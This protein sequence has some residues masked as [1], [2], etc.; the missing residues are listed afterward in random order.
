VRVPQPDDPRFRDVHRVWKSSGLSAQ[1]IANY[2]WWARVFVAD[3]RMRGRDPDSCLTRRGVV[4]FIEQREAPRGGTVA[5]AMRAGPSALWAWSWG[6]AAC[7]HVVPQWQPPPEP[8]KP[9]RR[10]LGQFVDYRREVCGVAAST[11][12]LDVANLNRFVAFLDERGRRPAR[13]RLVDVD[14]YLVHGS[15]RWAPRTLQGVAS[16]IRAFL[17]FLHVSGRLRHDLATSVLA[18]RERRDAHPPRALPWSDVRHILAAV[19]RSTRYGLRDHAL[20]LTMATYG[21]GAGEAFALTLDDID[22]RGGT[23][24]VVRPKTGREIVLPLLGPVARS[25]SA[26]LRRARPPHASSRVVFVQL[27]APFE[28]YRAAGAAWHVLRK[29][30]RAAG[31]SA[32]YL[33]SHVLR[34]SH[35][36]RHVDLGHPLKIVADILGHVDTETTSSY[37]RVSIRRLRSLALPVPS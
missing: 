31:V 7:G 32:P 18:P 15:R 26:Y 22:W 10:L 1:T 35:A 13:V 8:A 17:R 34:H 2:A 36:T 33:G 16:S 3:C 30:A 29:H 12:A 19:D 27:R 6:L 5:V 23:L 28:P 9:R 21:L 14:D 37:V 4:R 25:L 11:C 20:L 24:R